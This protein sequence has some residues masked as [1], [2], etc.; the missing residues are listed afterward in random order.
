MMKTSFLIMLSFFSIT[1]YRVWNNKKSTGELKESEE[2]MMM[3]ELDIRVGQDHVDFD[4]K[5]T[6]NTEDVV[7]LQFPSGQLFELNIY[8]DREVYRY[9]DEKMFTMAVVVKELQPGEQLIVNDQVSREILVTGEY[10]AKGYF[11]L[12]TVDGEEVESET[13]SVEKS[14][15]VE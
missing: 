7:E 1:H 3:T 5:L 8:Q 12:M 15:S 9:S 6:N 13:F 4:L 10:V 11:K 2:N 14:F